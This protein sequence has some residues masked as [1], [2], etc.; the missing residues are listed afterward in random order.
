MADP[1]ILVNNPACLPNRISIGRNDFDSERKVCFDRRSTKGSP[2][3]R[4]TW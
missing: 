4:T 2:G 1:S 3:S